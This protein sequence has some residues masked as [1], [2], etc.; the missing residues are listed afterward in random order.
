VLFTKNSLKDGEVNLIDKRKNNYG[1]NRKPIQPFFSS[2]KIIFYKAIIPILNNYIV[3]LSGE[4]AVGKT[5]LGKRLAYFFS[6][7]S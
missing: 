3:I 7:T 4:R 1:H 5:L 6:S 2:R